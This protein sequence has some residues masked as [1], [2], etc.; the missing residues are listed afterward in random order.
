M[1]N[2][3]A[4]SF[5]AERLDSRSRSFSKSTIDVRQFDSAPFCDSKLLK[6]DSMSIAA[7]CCPEL[8]LADAVISEVLASDAD[9]SV[10]LESVDV[11]CGVAASASELPTT[12]FQISPNILIVD[13]SFRQSHIRAI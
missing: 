4:S 5:R 11:A 8:A 6:I 13:A 2:S 9:V 12:L 10:V 3:S 1:L 7:G